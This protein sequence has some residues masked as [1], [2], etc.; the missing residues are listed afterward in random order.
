MNV[1]YLINRAVEEYPERMALIY[2][3]TRRTFSELNHRVNRLANGL[4]KAGIK[5]GDRVGMLLKNCCEFIEI[6]FALSKTGIVRVPLNA[7][8]TGLD[9]EYVLNDSGA[10]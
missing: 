3:N 1:K 8:L 9:H 5:K 2:K 4:L 7:R 6:D 10:N